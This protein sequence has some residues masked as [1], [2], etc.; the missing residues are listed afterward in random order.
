V[1]LDIPVSLYN[2]VSSNMDLNFIKKIAENTKLLVMQSE[3][4][5]SIAVLGEYNIPKGY[6]R[7]F[8]LFEE[9]SGRSI[10]KTIEERRERFNS[11]DTEILRQM[12]KEVESFSDWLKEVKG[13]QST[14]AHYYSVSLKS[15]LAG[16]PVGVTVGLLFGIVLYE[17]E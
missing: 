9:F 11:G 15:L 1:V 3:I 2:L 14:T 12:E 16:L 7:G 8:E 4:Q 6:L 5:E 13:F 17:Q 10:V